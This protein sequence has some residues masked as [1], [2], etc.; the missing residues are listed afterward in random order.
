MGLVVNLLLARAKAGVAF[1]IGNSDCESSDPVVFLFVAQLDLQL[2]VLVDKWRIAGRS[3]VCMAT[4]SF[5]KALVSAPRI[6]LARAISVLTE[7]KQ[8]KI[9]F[10]GKSAAR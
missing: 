1:W 3:I 7:V 4:S 8:G 5:F 10:V 2:T 9:V 6:R